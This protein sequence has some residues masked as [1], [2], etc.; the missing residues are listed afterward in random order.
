MEHFKNTVCFSFNL[1]NLFAKEM[2]KTTYKK[3]IGF[4]Q[5]II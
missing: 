5:W 4:T 3:V 1:H 2:L